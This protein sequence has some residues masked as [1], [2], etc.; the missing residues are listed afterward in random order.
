MKRF[1]I[2]CFIRKLSVFEVDCLSVG[3]GGY[4][5][6]SGYTGRVA[7]P[8]VFIFIT[9]IKIVGE[10]S[11]YGGMAC[12]CFVRMT[13]TRRACLVIWSSPGAGVQYPLV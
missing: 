5:S 9:T 4:E 11:P 2:N 10:E 7:L 1:I 3:I 6:G 13:F 12:S 8:L